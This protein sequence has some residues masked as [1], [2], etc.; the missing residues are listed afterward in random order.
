MPPR[1]GRGE[2]ASLLG[3]YTFASS[4]SDDSFIGALWGEA[5]AGYEHV[6]WSTGGVLDRP[7]AEL[8][9]GV[10][11]GVRRD[12]DGAPGTRRRRVGYFMDVRSFVGEA[13][14]DPSAPAQCGGPCTMATTPPRTDVSLFF[15]F[16]AFW[17]R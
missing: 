17:G 14:L 16:G 5:G 2:H 6:A 13:P 10:D 7:D 12:R 4:A 1:R 3:R 9:V 11:L 15:E 8:A